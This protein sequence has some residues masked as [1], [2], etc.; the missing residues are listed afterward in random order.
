MIVPVR[1]FAAAAEALGPHAQV[2]VPAPTTVGAV[3]DALI[4]AHP[5]HAALLR[6][7]SL[8]LDREIVLPDAPVPEGAE[9]AL[10]PPFA[11]GSH[12]PARGRDPA[13]GPEHRRGPDTPG[14]SPTEAD[15][16]HQDRDPHEAAGPR[17]II[18]VREPPL[19]VAEVLDALADPGAG[20]H[21]VFLGTVRDHSAA[22]GSVAQ[23]A[24]SAYEEMAREVLAAIARELATTWPALRGIALVHSVGALEVGDHTVLVVTS[25][26]HREDAY[27][28]NRRA[29]EEL[30]ARVPVWK[31]ERDAQGAARWVGLDATA[32]PDQGTTARPDQDAAAQ[33]EQ[34]PA[35]QPRE[36]R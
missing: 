35:A 13:G 5:E 10:L 36:P 2:E 31:H 6:Q 12:E 32:Q 30:K 24:Y 17:T 21:V 20:G 29:L 14:G 25:A 27:A 15:G 23:L 33:P 19:P 18:D 22:S 7:C 26:A 16:P 9:V 8:A 11:G 4:A 34:G 1:L 28:A 3:R